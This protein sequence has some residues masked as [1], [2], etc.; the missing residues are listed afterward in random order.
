MEITYADAQAPLEALL[1]SIERPGD[2]CTQGRLFVPM[3]R[4]EV[5]EAG[6]LS[7]PVTPPRAQALISVAERAPYGRGEETLVDSSVRACRQID[8]AQVTVGGGVWRDTLAQIV[9]HAASGLRLPARAYRSAPVQ[10]PG[11]R[12]RRVLRRAPGY[13]EGRRHGRHAGAVA[14]GRWRRR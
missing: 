13:R 12:S 7:F 4:V 8:A 5:G 6:M 10:A 9:A 1:Q 11:L 3:P 2:Y 14:S